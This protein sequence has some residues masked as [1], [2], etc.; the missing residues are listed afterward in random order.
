M[1]CLP[2]AYHLIC[3][4]FVQGGVPSNTRQELFGIIDTVVLTR[5][6]FCKLQPANQIQSVP[7]EV[8]TFLKSLKQPKKINQNTS[9]R[10]MWSAKPKISSGSVQKKLLTLELE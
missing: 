4:E 2:S 1:V 10:H 5:A 9:Q 7:K 3:L 6:A 8:F